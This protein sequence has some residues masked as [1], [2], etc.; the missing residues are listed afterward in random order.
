[1]TEHSSAKSPLGP[2]GGSAANQGAPAPPEASPAAPQEPEA[3][4][5]A[6]VVERQVPQY[7]SPTNHLESALG[8]L[9]VKAQFSP[10]AQIT[11]DPITNDVVAVPHANLETVFQVPFCVCGGGG[12]PLSNAERRLVAHV[13]CHMDGLMS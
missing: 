8:L 13:Y 9:D 10:L 6:L 5:S 2:I 12:Y 7:P 1:M 3:K 4:P 11:G